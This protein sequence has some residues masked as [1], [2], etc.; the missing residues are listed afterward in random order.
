MK[1]LSVC[2][3]ADEHQWGQVTVARRFSA[4]TQRRSAQSDLSG[5]PWHHYIDVL[6][7]LD[8]SNRLLVQPIDLSLPAHWKEWQS[9]FRRLDVNLSLW[10]ETLP[11]HMSDL[12]AP[13]DPVKTLVH[14]TF[15]L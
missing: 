1:H 14:S 8:R 2:Y 9:K 11:H 3:P 10:F 4:S 5:N 15:N 7:L 6:A 12:Q 13:F